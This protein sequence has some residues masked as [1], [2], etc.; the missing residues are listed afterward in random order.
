MI[1]EF[2]DDNTVNNLRHVVIISPDE[3]IL[4]GMN[5]NI[6]VPPPEIQESNT[7]LQTVWQVTFR[8]PFIIIQVLLTICAVLLCSLTPIFLTFNILVYITDSLNMY[9]S[10]IT[11]IYV[12]RFRQR[13]F[14]DV[15][16]VRRH[17]TYGDSQIR[18][19]IGYSLIMFLIFT[20]L[21]V[22]HLDNPRFHK[23]Q[24]QYTMRSCSYLLQLFGTVL[25][26]ITCLVHRIN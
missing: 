2:I 12:T 22:I 13:N 25:L 26:N 15:D 18:L 3:N 11:L 20:I 9:V 6:S 21:S 10:I 1:I 8:I 14:H 23:L 5:E 19:C 17:L 7:P 24:Y 4:I 16:L